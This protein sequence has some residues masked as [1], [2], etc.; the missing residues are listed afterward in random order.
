[1]AYNHQQEERRRREQR[2][3]A[4]GDV[5]GTSRLLSSPRRE[6][7]ELPTGAMP[8]P[9]QAPQPLAPTARWC[10]ACVCLFLLTFISITAIVLL[11]D[12][13][14]GNAKPRDASTT[15]WELL[16]GQGGDENVGID[17]FGVANWLYRYDSYDSYYSYDAPNGSVPSGPGLRPMQP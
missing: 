1:M 4:A 16:T 5:E 15:I 14:F 10:F 2:L 13:L 9:Y 11:G 17:P 7:G 8:P 12:H 3:R 6:T